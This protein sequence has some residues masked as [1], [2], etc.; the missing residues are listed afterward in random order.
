MKV[1]CSNLCWRLRSFNFYLNTSYAFY[2]LNVHILK[3]LIKKPR[4][5]LYVHVEKE[6][7]VIK[8][9]VTLEVGRKCIFTE[10]NRVC[11]GQKVNRFES[12]SHRLSSVHDSCCRLCA[13]Y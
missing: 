3:S 12:V 11:M 13:L 5:S 8:D 4:L 2:I 10:H 1:V 7:L 6:C 9:F